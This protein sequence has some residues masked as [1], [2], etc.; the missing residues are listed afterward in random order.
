MDEKVL[1]MNKCY[2]LISKQKYFLTLPKN[3]KRHIHKKGTFKW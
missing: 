3:I 1:F 2:K